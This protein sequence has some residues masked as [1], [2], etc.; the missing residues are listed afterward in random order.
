MPSIRL[1]R[2]L[3]LSLASGLSLIALHAILEEAPTIPAA[4]TF[5]NDTFMVVGG[6]EVNSST[7]FK[8][9]YKVLTRRE[10]KFAG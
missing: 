4:Q 9:E 8:K 5:R 6:E 2:I 1:S 3:G 10:N 7:L